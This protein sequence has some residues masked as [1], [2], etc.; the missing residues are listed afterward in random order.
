MSE[1]NRESLL[2]F[3]CEFPIKMMGRVGE[4]FRETAVVLVEKHSGKVSEDAIS[5]AASRNGNF[6]SVTVTIVA[7]NQEQLDNIYRELT[8]H[9][10]ILVAL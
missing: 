5:V 7:Q 4:G 9:E 3:P 2:E 10:E 1:G 6:I 8:G